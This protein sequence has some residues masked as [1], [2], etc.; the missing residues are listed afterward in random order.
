MNR[1]FLDEREDSEPE[2]EY[3]LP[4]NENNDN[5]NEREEEEENINFDLAI[6][7]PQRYIKKKRKRD[8]EDEEKG[9]RIDLDEFNSAEEEDLEDNGSLEDFIVRDD[10]I[11]TEEVTTRRPTRLIVSESEDETDEED[12]AHRYNFDVNREA[13]EENNN[14]QERTSVPADLQHPVTPDTTLHNQILAGQIDNMLENSDDGTYRPLYDSFDR[15]K[16]DIDVWYETIIVPLNSSDGTDNENERLSKLFLATCGL[17]GVDLN[18]LQE[19]NATIVEEHYLKLYRQLLIWYLELEFRN[20]WQQPLEEPDEAELME[21]NQQ[22]NNEYAEKVRHMISVAFHARIIWRSFHHITL[23]SN[24]NIAG[25]LDDKLLVQCNPLATQNI[26]KD[27][28]KP[29]IFKNTYQSAF[30]QMIRRKRD[31]SFIYQAVFNDKK[32]FT[33]AWEKIAYSDS[34]KEDYKTIR[35]FVL[36]NANQFTNYELFRAVTNNSTSLK[37]ICQVFE[38][39]PNELWP[40]LEEQPDVYAFQE[41][42][43]IIR[44]LEL[45]PLL[46]ANK[47]SPLDPRLL[48]PQF[49]TYGSVPQF[50]GKHVCATKYFDLHFDSNWLN[51]ET[52]W[53]EIPT[54]HFNQIGRSQEWHRIRRKGSDGRPEN[55]VAT[56]TGLSVLDTLYFMIGR[57]L[58][59]VGQM[60]N[61]QIMP[62][63]YG[64]NSTGKTTLCQ[65]IQNLFNSDDFGQMSNKGEDVFGLA[66][67][68]HYRVVIASEIRKN[69]NLDQAKWQQMVAGE[70]M[71]IPRKHKDAI[72]VQWLAHLLFASNQ[73]MALDDSHGAV[74]RRILMFIFGKFVQADPTLAKNIQN[75]YAKILVKSIR[76]YFETLPLIGK[77]SVW[78]PGILPDYFMTNRLIIQKLNSI[79]HWI[80]QENEIFELRPN[81]KMPFS[82]FQTE[83]NKWCSQRQKKPPDWQTG[84]EIYDKA[85]HDFNITVDPD[86]QNTEEYHGVS[87]TQVFL[88]GIDLKSNSGSSNNNNG[89]QGGPNARQN[90]FP[91][92]GGARRNPTTET[93]PIVPP[94]TQPPTPTRRRQRNT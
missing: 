60:D 23:I 6:T 25:M 71:Q 38:E 79:L 36:S 13:E 94:D 17:V 32:Q 3:A 68:Y 39:Q 11:E 67:L 9:D 8:S 26:Q 34:R 80:L 30:F 51:T 74:S 91:Q 72:N 89:G 22:Y 75:E 47:I 16:N 78:A 66:S 42:L 20:Q 49:F 92:F 27:Q 31:S 53:R 4:H 54:P 61:F 63:F 65:I 86:K 33:H 18:N 82:L 43:L 5:N 52:P 69:L 57:M 1:L 85:F 70:F 19:L 73:I 55:D 50:S 14:N 28:D 21:A 76:C 83:V 90:L 58:F 45:L 10:E 59:P 24:G 56:I 62:F 46:Q 81:L 44:P 87:I 48:K 40:F 2:F 12:V 15:L 88:Y 7:P 29:M 84:S 64:K 35:N 41:G 37:Q 77:N 93:V